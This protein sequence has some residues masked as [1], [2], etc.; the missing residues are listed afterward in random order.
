MKRLF[1]WLYRQATEPIRDGEEIRRRE[2]V[3]RIYKSYSSNEHHRTKL[4]FA[5]MNR[6]IKLRNE[7]AEQSLKTKLVK[8]EW[9][10]K[11]S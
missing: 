8:W 2:A 11:L 4:D 1:A 3:K 5:I 7:Q 9:L 6:H 10:R